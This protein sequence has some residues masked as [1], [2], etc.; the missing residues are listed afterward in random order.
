MRICRS[1][2]LPAFQENSRPSTQSRLAPTDI[3]PSRF[4]TKN[5]STRFD[6]S[7]NRAIGG[8][9]AHQREPE[10]TPGPAKAGPFVACISYI[11]KLWVA[12]RMMIAR[13]KVVIPIRAVL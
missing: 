11:V 9:R 12:P 13:T 5:S 8:K 7:F 4:T 6:A 2:S 10:R 1:F 3:F